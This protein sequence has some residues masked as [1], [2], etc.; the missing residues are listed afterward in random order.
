MVRKQR[1]IAQL[2]TIYPRLGDVFGNVARSQ[3][4]YP[5]I[6]KAGRVVLIK[7][8]ACLRKELSPAW[9]C[10]AGRPGAISVV[11]DMLSMVLGIISLGNRR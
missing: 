1:I 9:G 8:P 6:A 5:P 2:I 4:D 11:L 10:V 7:H 3:L